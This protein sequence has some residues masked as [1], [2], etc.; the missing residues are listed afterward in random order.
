MTMS[1]HN[2]TTTVCQETTATRAT[3]RNVRQ[4]DTDT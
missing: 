2:G 4:N 3:Q 1:Q